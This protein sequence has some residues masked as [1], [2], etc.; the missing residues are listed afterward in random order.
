MANGHFGE[1]LRQ[2]GK[3]SETPF[4]DAEVVDPILQTIGSVQMMG[5][6]IGRAAPLSL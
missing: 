2:G 5:N 1:A 6:S 3:D 4:S